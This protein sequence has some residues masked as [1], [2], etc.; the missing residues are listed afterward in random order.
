MSPQPQKLSVKFEEMPAIPIEVSTAP[1]PREPA[2]SLIRRV[3][4][5]WTACG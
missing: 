1:P 4:Q 3:W 5:R 2:G